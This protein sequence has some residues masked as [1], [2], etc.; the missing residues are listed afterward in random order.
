VYGSA[1]N[2]VAIIVVVFFGIIA[3]YFMFQS[4]AETVQPLIVNNSSI[5]GSEIRPWKMIVRI[6]RIPRIMRYQFHS[7]NRHS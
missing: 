6:N 4:H 7:R 3:L 5:G 1:S 2:I